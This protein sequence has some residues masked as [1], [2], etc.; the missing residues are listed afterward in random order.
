MRE[1]LRDY[2]GDKIRVIATVAKYGVREIRGKTFQ[3]TLMLSDVRLAETDD[4]LCD[5]MW[6]VGPKPFR[7]AGVKAGMVV[8]FTSRVYTYTKV[9]PDATSDDDLTETERAADETV[10]KCSAGCLSSG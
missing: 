4:L 9:N 6:F 8:T 2:L 7:R 1:G 5:H 3:E 10:S